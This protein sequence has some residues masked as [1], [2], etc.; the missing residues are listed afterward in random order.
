MDEIDKLAREFVE[1]V[2]RPLADM[3]AQW[4]DDRRR[5]IGRLVQEGATLSMEAAQLHIESCVDLLS[6]GIYELPSSAPTSIMDI[7]VLA[8]FSDLEF[9][10]YRPALAQSAE[11]PGE[12]IMAT[13]AIRT[14]ENAELISPDD[15]LFSQYG[16]LAIGNGNRRRYGPLV[17]TTEGCYVVGLDVVFPAGSDA[18]Y[19]IYP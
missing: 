17:F 2:N 6:R 7:A 11:F 4:L 18:Y 16:E 12:E 3:S 5:E 10:D 15:V 8:T 19:R 14:L 9:Q 13:V 1:Y